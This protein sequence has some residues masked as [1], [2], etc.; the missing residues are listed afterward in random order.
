MGQRLDSTVRFNIYE[1]R[2]IICGDLWQKYNQ[3]MDPTEAV[4]RVGA[5]EP[6]GITECRR[7]SDRV[8]GGGYYS[9]HFGV[10]GFCKSCVEEMEE[11]RGFLLIKACTRCGGICG[12][13]AIQHMEGCRS[14]SYSDTSAGGQYHCAPCCVSSG[15]TCPQRPETFDLPCYRTD[16]EIPGSSAPI[17]GEM[18]IGHR[19]MIKPDGEG[20][21]SV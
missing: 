20:H 8:F 10:H 11:T 17:C 16:R 1:R 4:R 6:D 15:C 14:S 12:A 2:V 3:M 5:E 19:N 7:C 9:D 21:S 13:P 18:V